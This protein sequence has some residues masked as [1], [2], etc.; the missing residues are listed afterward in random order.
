M[1]DFFQSILPRIQNQSKK[2]N[3]IE[4][5]VEKP[6]V[7]VDETTTELLEYEFF[8]DGRLLVSRGGN[9]AWGKWEL[10]PSSQRLIL[11]YGEKLLLLNTAFMDDAIMI[12]QKSG[13]F[14]STLVFVNQKKIPDLL[15][16]AYLENLAEVEKFEK[17]IAQHL[18]KP[19]KKTEDFS[20]KQEE[21]LPTAIQEAYE[22]SYPNIFNQD[23][24][25][26]SG[27]VWSETHPNLYYK[28]EQGGKLDEKWYSLSIKTLSGKELLF[29]TPILG[30][31][32]LKAQLISIDRNYEFDKYNRNE[33]VET[34][35][36][37]ETVSIDENN[38]VTKTTMGY[39]RSSWKEVSILIITL[40]A[41]MFTIFYFS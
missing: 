34:W 36:G 18:Q 16:K 28:Y 19:A 41:I 11:E 26:L 23:G 27:F 35:R 32:V 24:D 31:L 4:L 12:V 8:R 5:F 40:V 39:N 2:L 14:E 30:D 1:K 38:K 6:W 9:A 7:L 37:V 33:A 3:Q 25:V 17:A 10:A 29:L 13:A 21:D 22:I 20:R 15:Y